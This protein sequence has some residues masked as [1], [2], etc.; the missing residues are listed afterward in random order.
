MALEQILQALT[1]DT[2]RQIAELKQAAAAQ[3]AEIRAHAC[4]EAQR[5]QQAE[6]DAIQTA[7]QREQ[8]RIL[9]RAKQAALQTRLRTREQVMQ[10][11]LAAGAQR[12]TAFCATDDY[13]KL[14]HELTREAVAALTA[15][16]GL[17]FVVRPDDAELM[18]EI[19]ADL[20]VAARIKSDLS[21]QDDLGGVIVTTHD[22]RIQLNN[23]VKMRLHQ[24]TERYRAQIADIVFGNGQEA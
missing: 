14:L 13:A 6:H 2:D 15:S 7:R 9:N 8:A 1:N 20:G 19:A 12:L 18:Q 17:Q 5:V 23:T 21:V 10:S 16:D 22:G 24:V 11:A 3:I 4:A